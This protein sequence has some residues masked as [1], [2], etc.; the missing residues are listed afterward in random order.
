M[1]GHAFVH[2][3]G[4]GGIKGVS[5]PIPQLYQSEWSAAWSLKKWTLVP[6]E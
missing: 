1:L 2:Y 3:E 5:P 4:V 6:I